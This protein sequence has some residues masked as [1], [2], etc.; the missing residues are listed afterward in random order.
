MPKGF[1]P[2]AIIALALSAAFSCCLAAGAYEV[3]PYQVFRAAKNLVD[4]EDGKRDPLVYIDNP[5]AV[6]VGRSDPQ[7][8]TSADVVMIG[9]S[10]TAS[11]RVEEMFPASNVVNRGVGGDTVQGV[12]D[13]LSGILELRPKQA[14]LLIGI[15]DIIFDNPVPKVVSRYEQVLTKLEQ[16][17]V[18]PV[19]QSVIVCGKAPICTPER[20]EAAR[21]LNRELRDLAASRKIQFVDLNARLSSE[22][23]VQGKYTWDGIHLNAEGNRV[24]RDTIQPMMMRSGD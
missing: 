19:V 9:D 21:L 3:F 13:R 20:R 10:I 4:G 2:S 11:A 24:W 17:G 8:G 12:L 7:W 6:E 15:N 5:L 14:F 18:Q 22:D 16:E 23:G 1:Q